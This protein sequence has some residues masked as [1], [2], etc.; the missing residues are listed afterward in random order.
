MA[1]TVGAVPSFPLSGRALLQSGLEKI[2]LAG[3][4]VLAGEET[5]A[6]RG[7]TSLI[8]L[9]EQYMGELELFNAV[10][11]LVGADTRDDLIVRHILD[12]LAPWK[13]V[14]ALLARKAGSTLADAGTG[15]GFPGIPLALLFPQTPVFLL[16][17]MSKRCAFLNGLRAVLRL[18]TVSVL[19]GEIEK[20]SGPYD[21]V[22]FR[23]FRP[24][25]PPMFTAL[26]RLVCP[27]GSLAAWKARR[28][29][30]EAEMAP[31]GREGVLWESKPVQVPFLD[32]EERHLVIIPR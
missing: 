23:A 13:A 14:A 28:D 9:L 32:H 11:D 25:E 31:L 16:E 29:K 10:F 24:L 2:G 6:R 22:V 3:E 15:A 17:R 30:I 1:K 20:A 19:E 18:S 27:G 26:S 21:V 5:P 8:P 4:D 12:S 7:A